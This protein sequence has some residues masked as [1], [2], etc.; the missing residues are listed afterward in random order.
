MFIEPD[1]YLIIMDMNE[2]DTDVSL[3]LAE[4]KML[5]GAGVKTVYLQGLIRWERMQPDKNMD[6]DWAVPDGFVERARD[7]GLKMLIPCLFSLPKWLPDEFFYSRKSNGQLYD[8]PAYDNPEAAE[9]IDDFIMT[10]CDRYYGSDAQV[11]YSIPGNGEFALNGHG[12]MDYPMEVFT[13]WVV[14]RQRILAAQHNEIWTAFHPYFD[15]GYWK[16]L[17]GALFSAFPYDQHYGI[18][19]TYVQHKMEHIQELL[20]YCREYGMK[21]YGGTEYVQGM[22]SN[23]PF[24]METKTRMLTAPKHPYQR[25]S[26]IEPWMLDEIIWATRQYTVNL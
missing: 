23:V 15:P 21:Y 25:Y 16:H 9:M 19:F 11:I 4:M 6:V 3:T 12:R 18:I 13:D 7:A 1:E 22:R 26:E 20:N 5:K 17:Y 8:V 10:V 14:E 2:R 24:L